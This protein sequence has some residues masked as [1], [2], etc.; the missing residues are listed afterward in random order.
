VL[1]FEEKA[2]RITS[3]LQAAHCLHIYR[4]ELTLHGS[5]EKNKASSHD[6]EGAKR[7]I[8]QGAAQKSQVT[9]EGVA[10]Q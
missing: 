8:N 1:N 7:Y 10:A 9:V 4:I 5:K 3:I 6:L 2:S